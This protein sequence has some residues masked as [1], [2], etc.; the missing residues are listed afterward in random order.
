MKTKYKSDSLYWIW[1]TEILGAGGRYTAR[2]AEAFGT[3]FDIYNATEEE[4]VRS[5]CVTDEIAHKLADKSLKKAHHII[6][7]CSLNNIG[8]LSYSSEYYPSSLKTLQNPPGVLYYKGDL[9][10]FDE[11]LCIGMVGT[12]KMS[13]YGK[14]AAYKIAYELASAGAIVVS[15]MALGIDAVASC[16][17]LVAEGKTVAVLG[18]G[19]DVAYPSQH[20]KLKRIIEDRGLIISEFAPGTRPYGSNFPIRNRLISGL[21]QGTLIVEADENS[22]AMITAKCALMQ[23]RGVFAVPGNIDES[24]SVGTNKLIKDGATP[25]VTADDILSNYEALYGKYL[26]YSALSF[27]RSIYNYDLSDEAF[28][29]MG[30]SM[31]V[32]EKHITPKESSSQLRPTRRPQMREDEVL[33][34]TNKSNAHSKPPIVNTPRR[35]SDGSEAILAELDESIKKIF[36]DFPIDRAVTIDSLLALGHSANEIMSAVTILEIKGLI[37]SLPGNLYVRR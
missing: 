3:A 9:L 14:K 19:I 8:I 7:Y 5:G 34:T 21:S 4:L 2:L 10:N 28:E 29:K 12:R 23:G 24:N 17:A 22:G 15:G 33:A 18:C 35:V 13:E 27:A 30:I 32:S 37:S 36:N 26:N 11:K 31:R 1:M 6:D 20:A 16:G 25:V